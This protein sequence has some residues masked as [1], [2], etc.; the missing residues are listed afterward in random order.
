[1]WPLRH[2]GVHWFVHWLTSLGLEHRAEA[3][4]DAEVTASAPLTAPGV[5]LK[6]RAVA[7]VCGRVVGAQGGGGERSA[8]GG[9]L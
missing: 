4:R 7:S 6:P 9:R 5:P 3:L 8:A 1:V 2:A